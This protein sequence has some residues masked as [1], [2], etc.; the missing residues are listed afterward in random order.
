MSVDI[1]FK[2]PRRTV[3]F[4]PVLKSSCGFLMGDYDPLAPP[5]KHVPQKPRPVSSYPIK[6]DFS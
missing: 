3:P 6:I 2:T 5:P 1:G 4:K